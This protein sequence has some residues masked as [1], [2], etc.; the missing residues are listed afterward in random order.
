MEKDSL[1][2]IKDNDIISVLYRKYYKALV[3]F[4]CSL[5]NDMGEAEDVVQDVIMKMWRGNLQ[6]GNESK[7]KSYLWTAVRNESVS[8]HNHIKV[9][10]KYKDSVLNE[11]GGVE[12][13]DDSAD[14]ISRE[15][16]YRQLFAAID[17]LPPKQ[18]ELF[19]HVMEGKKNSEIAEAMNVS[20]N[21]VKAQRLRGM[22]YLRSRVKAPALMV[23]LVLEE[24]SI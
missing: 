17:E 10:E 19:L 14:V 6:F 21:T 3:V 2:S 18:R 15:E 12:P 22:E 13:D 1:I 4:A 9:I 8:R 23:L 20:I 7:M 11:N 24:L 16:V 5:I